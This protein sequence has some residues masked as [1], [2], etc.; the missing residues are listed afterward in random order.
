MIVPENN[1]SINQTGYTPIVDSI[2]EFNV[3][4]NSLSA[5]YGRTGGGVINV[6]TRSGTNEFHGSLFEFLRNAKLDANSW[7][8][9]RN[10]TPRA[11]FQRNQFGGTIG[12]PI[13]IPGLYDG[14]NRTFF[15]FA[16]PEDTRS[17]DS[18]NGHRNRAARR[19]APRRLLDLR[20]GN[21]QLIT[22]LRSADGVLRICLRHAQ[23]RLCTSSFP[24][25]PI[26]LERFDPVARQCL[27]FFPLPNAV[28]TN[29]FSNQNNF[30]ASGKAA[31]DE[32]KFDSRV[33]HNFSENASDV[34]S[35]LAFRRFRQS[36]QRLWK[37]RFLDR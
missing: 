23:C 28:P 27:K 4:T 13:S 21:G 12:G 2:A 35:L 29:Q 8:N 11:A 26:P 19:V 14:E 24:R 3:I 7:A 1:V 20:N 37:H 15:F 9:N 33:D 22:H 25:Q 6:A 36:V 32:D 30:F 5:E 17:A 10:R 16:V 31:N 18:A 34:R